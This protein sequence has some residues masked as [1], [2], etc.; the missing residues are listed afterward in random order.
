MQEM[1]ALWNITVSIQKVL[2]KMV[3]FQAAWG[4]S[5]IF[6]MFWFRIIWKIKARD[7]QL[8]FLLLNL[9]VAQFCVSKMW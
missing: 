1:N 8:G 2:P 7:V 5:E 9:N 4:N 6:A 3:T